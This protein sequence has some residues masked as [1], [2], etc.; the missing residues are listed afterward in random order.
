MTR[1][2][3]PDGPGPARVRG[4]FANSGF[5]TFPPDAVDVLLVRHGESAPY[6]DGEPHPLHEGH[7]DPPLSPRG[8]EQAAALA[9]RLAGAGI[10]AAYASDLRRTRQTAA[11]LLARTGLDLRVVAALREVNLGE[12]EGGLYRKM[13]AEGH[14][15]FV[16]HV[17]TGRWAAIPGA[18]DD[19][20][21]R[22]RVVGAMDEILASHPG[23]RVL[24][25]SHG[26]VIDAYLTALWGLE[27]SFVVGVDQTSITQVVSS[28]GRAVV[29]RVNDTSHLGDPLRLPVRRPREPPGD[30]QAQP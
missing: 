13:G 4:T 5:P 16:E 11:P 10:T 29:R 27:R 2:T 1:E 17:V 20:A 28:G 23:E 7:G 6:V 21:L 26:G 9:A 22:R 8:E 12:W 3:T 18:E 25:V 30:Q 19:A 14:P 24:V 15:R